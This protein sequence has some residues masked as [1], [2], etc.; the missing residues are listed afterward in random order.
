MY[1]KLESGDTLY[2]HEVLEILLF[3]ACPRVN[4][5]PVAHALLDRFCSLNGVLGASLEEL[6]TVKGVGKHTASFLKTVALC[7]RRAGS[8]EGAAVLKTFGDCKK[9][10]E[11]RLK[12][13]T[14]E[15]LEL[16][17]L[18]KNGCVKRIFSY[19]SADR[20]RVEADMDEVV[21]N[22]VLSKPHGLLAAHNHLNGSSEPSENDDNFTRTLQLICNLH[23]V[24]LWDHLIYSGGFYSYKDS[25]RLDKISEE[26]SFNNL[27]KWTKTSN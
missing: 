26:L 22:I 5:N 2:D 3:T 8:I 19:T 17:F 24:K 11:M 13:R 4:T 27:M 15:Y 9:F 18:E 12:G 7:M 20:N 10:A 6:T 1:A 16:Y 14:E 25:G 23:G 21:R